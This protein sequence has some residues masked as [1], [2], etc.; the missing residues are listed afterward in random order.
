KLY[1]SGPYQTEASQDLVRIIAERSTP[2]PVAEERLQASKKNLDELVK[3]EKDYPTDPQIKYYLGN[4][5]YELGQ[6]KDAGRYYFQA[7]AFEAAYK[8][9]ELI[10]ERLFINGQGEPETLTPTVLQQLEKERNPL[11]VFDK[12]TYYERNHQ[13]AFNG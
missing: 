9:K 11:V 2:N 1:P 5:Y 6:Y 10:K 3:L 7:Q 8:E 12:R 4:I 13:D